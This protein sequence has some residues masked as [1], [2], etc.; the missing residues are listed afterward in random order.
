MSKTSRKG[1]RIF[2][3]Y[4]F[5]LLFAR[6]LFELF[7]VCSKSPLDLSLNTTNS[8]KRASLYPSKSSVIEFEKHL[9]WTDV[10]CIAPNELKPR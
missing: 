4:F 1:R 3:S 5:S 2:R 10:R 8:M 6:L 9:E 7:F